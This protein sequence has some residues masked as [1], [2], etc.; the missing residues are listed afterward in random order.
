MTAALIDYGEGGWRTIAHNANLPGWLVC[1]MSLG[2]SVP[3]LW[4]RRHLLPVLTALS[5]VALANS[6]TGAV[7]QAALLQL[8][9]LFNIALRLP[10]RTLVGGGAGD[11]GLTS[12]APSAF[13]PTAGTSKSSPA[14]GLSASSPFSESRSAP[15]GTTQKH[16]STAP[17]A[18]RWNAT[19]RPSSPP[20]PN[21][22]V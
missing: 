4:R 7:L 8:F 15:A 21:T 3:L 13:R 1:S 12:R 2:L 11:G 5:L 10:L 22:P 17:V 16:W 18:W 19:S 14:S 9:P 20:P 6:L